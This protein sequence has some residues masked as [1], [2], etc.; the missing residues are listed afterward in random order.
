M[1]ILRAIWSRITDEP[2]MTLALLNAAVLLAV[3]FGLKLTAEQ[4]ALV[5]SFLAA[6]LGWIARKNVTPA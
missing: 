5:G 1:T 6:F 3:G 2:V 4:I